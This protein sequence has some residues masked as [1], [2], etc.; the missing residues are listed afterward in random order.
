MVTVTITGPSGIGKSTLKRHL[1]KCFSFE[2][3]PVYTTREIRTDDTDSERISLGLKEFQQMT[4]REEL[5]F[6]NEIFGNRYGFEKS[7][8]SDLKNKSGRFITELYIDN[9]RGFREM[10]PLSNMIALTTESRDFLEY[11]LRKRNECYSSLI[12]RLREADYELRKIM[13]SR[14]LFNLVY[15]VGFSNEHRVFQDIADYVG[16]EIQICTQ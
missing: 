2:E 7:Y 8:L 12:H 3:I 14:D 10:V 5:T 15:N 4:D 16:K 13:E 11:R 6:V 1:K 9:V